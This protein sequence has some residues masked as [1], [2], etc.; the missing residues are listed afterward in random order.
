MPAR[1]RGLIPNRVPA[2]PPRAAPRRT[3]RRT[4][5]PGRCAGSTRRGR[6]RAPR[7]RSELGRAAVHGA[8]GDA[9]L[10]TTRISAADRNGDGQ[11]TGHDLLPGEPVTVTARLPRGLA[12]LPALVPAR[13]LATEGLLR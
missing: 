10:R 4:G 11:R 1:S 2:R 9:R 12:E 7:A 6:R 13:R 3:A 8:D 5:S